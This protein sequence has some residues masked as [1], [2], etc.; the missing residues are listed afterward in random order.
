MGSGRHRQGSPLRISHYIKNKS[1][2]LFLITLFQ[3]IV[4]FNT[5]LRQ[6]VLFPGDISG[7]HTVLLSP[8]KQNVAAD[9]TV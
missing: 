6:N 4:T 7:I 5:K 3:I 8:Q 1:L 9:F 2:Q